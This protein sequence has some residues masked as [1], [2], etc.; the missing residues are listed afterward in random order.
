MGLDTSEAF[1]ERASRTAKPPGQ[2]ADVVLEA[3]RDD[4]FYVFADEALDQRVRPR[5][6]AV[7]SA[8]NP[9]VPPR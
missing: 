1:R 5:L 2:V 4:R 9:P 8:S 3:I 7:L 6:E